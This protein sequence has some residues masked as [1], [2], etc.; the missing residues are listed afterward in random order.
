MSLNRC[1]DCEY[2]VAKESKT[3]E[4]GCSHPNNMVADPDTGAARPAAG[5]HTLRLMPSMC[6]PSGKW[7][8]AKA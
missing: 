6:V 3:D 4:R 8:K 2:A 5:A 1:V 7:F